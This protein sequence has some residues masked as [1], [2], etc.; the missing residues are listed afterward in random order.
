MNTILWSALALASAQA[1][2]DPLSTGPASSGPISGDDERK[3]TVDER[4]STIESKLAAQ[5]TEAKPSDSAITAAFKDGFKFESA[6]KSF[7]AS[8][9]GRLHVDAAAFSTDDD[10]EAGIGREEDGM[11]VR[12]ARLQFQAELYEQVEFKW[13]Y[14]FAG[15]TDNK[16]KDVYLGLKETPIGGLRAGQFK[17]PMSLEELT[18]SNHRTFME[19]A[20]MNALVPSRNV[21]VMLHDH[22]EA[23]TMTWGVGLFRDDGADTGIN[24]GDGENSV[25]GRVTYLPIYADEGRHLLHLG[26][27][28]SIREGDEETF[29]IRSR[30]PSGL[31]TND[32]VDT[33]TFGADSEDLFNLEAAWVY[34]PFSLQGE[35]TQ[36]TFD[37]TGDPEATGWYAYA[38]YFLT[39]ENRA[40]KTTT[41]AFD[42]L[43]PKQNYGAGSGAWEVK[44]GLSELDLSDS[45]L[46]GGEVNDYMAGVSW[47]LNPFTRVMA[48]YVRQEAEPGGGLADGSMDIL[49]ARFQVEL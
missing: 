43:K 35:F 41:G 31:L 10:Y 29:R 12:R 18:S 19:A 37:T 5:A 8:L 49:Q 6:D 20:P 7:K 24:S 44:V 23:K 1:P 25:T 21:G 46:D 32:V 13:V 27:A 11:R 3:P 14:D 22:N 38:T 36:A 16:L 26:V 40:Y 2:S 9:G 34:G 15:G 47:Y 48:E 17:E 42:R 45:G 30:G 33:G 4:L 28:A 39:G